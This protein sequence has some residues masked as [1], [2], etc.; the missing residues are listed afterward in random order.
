MRRAIQGVHR[1]TAIYRSSIRTSHKSTSNN[2]SHNTAASAKLFADAARE[3]AEVRSQPRS[4]SHL[5]L[6]E[7][8]HENWTGDESTQ[9]AVLRMLVDKYKPLRSGSIQS[10]EQRLKWNPPKVWSAGQTSTVPSATTRSWATQPLL[11]SSE[12]HRP[13]HTEFKAPSHATSSIKHT[14]IP[15]ASGRKPSVIPLDDRARRKEK[16]AQK[17]GERVG[18]LALARESILDYRLGMKRAGEAVRRVN[19]LSLKGWAGL[20]EDKIQVG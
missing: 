1:Y 16:E 14:N 9:D 17:K 11:P 5:T 4:P 2:A 12:D 10:A 19:P 7:S 15:P 3:E 20:I 8:Q 6:L 13:W 18:R